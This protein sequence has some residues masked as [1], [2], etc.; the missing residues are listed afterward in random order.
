MFLGWF[1]VK[2]QV[3]VV[4]YINEKAEIR[5]EQLIV[6]K[7]QLSDFEAIAK[8]IA[9]QNQTPETHCIHSDTGQDTQNILG[10]M[11]R[12]D[13]EGEICF[14]TASVDGQVTAAMGCEFDLELG[15]GWLRGPFVAAGL[16]DWSA[17]AARL[18]DGLLKVL[19]ESIRQ[20]DT[21]LNIKNIR[22]NTFYLSRDFE[23]IRLVQV[24]EC[25]PP[26]TNCHPGDG[27][28]PLTREAPQGFIELHDM[29]FP[30][31]Y[32]TGQRILDK[33]DERHQVFVYRNNGAI[34][35]YC[36][37]NIDED[38]G[39]G[40]LDF[41]GVREDARG[42]GIGRLLV[43]TALHWFFEVKKLPKVILVVHDDLSNARSLYESVGFKLKY[44]GVHNRKIRD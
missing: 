44:T 12:L 26:Q 30:G 6:Q 9:S 39:E 37:A 13:A 4:I 15:R 41:L 34:I 1:N 24:Y 36:C 38:T 28:E 11:I 27:C 17:T 8:T 3:R 25:L 31:T 14:V 23:R 5:M 29:I 21:Y 35:G 18:F 43:Q 20:L 16:D 10:E 2:Y 32:A 40:A 42:K 7:A 22:G 33:I 19:P